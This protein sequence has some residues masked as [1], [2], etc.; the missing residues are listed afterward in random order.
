MLALHGLPDFPQILWTLRAGTA[1]LFNGTASKSSLQLPPFLPLP[2]LD[3]ENLCPGV[4][5]R[6]GEPACD[7]VK[8]EFIAGDAGCFRSL[9]KKRYAL[10]PGPAFLSGTV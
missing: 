3:I 10:P 1:A 4:W 9:H 7:S 6:L 2:T 5:G 8:A